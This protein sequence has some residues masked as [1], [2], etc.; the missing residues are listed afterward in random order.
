MAVGE[1]AMTPFFE[2]AL[3]LVVSGALLILLVG[4]L[5]IGKR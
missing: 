4:V 2:F 3:I 1:H 5:L